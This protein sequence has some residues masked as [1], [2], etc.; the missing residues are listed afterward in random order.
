MGEGMQRTGELVG[1]EFRQIFRDPRMW[2][3]V[4]IAPIIQLLVFGYAVSTDVRNTALFVVDHDQ[5]QL[6]RAL[7]DSMTSSGYFRLVGTSERS[8]DVVGMLDHARAV[9]A[10]QIPPGFAADLQSGKGTVQLLFDGTNSNVA[11][12]A[13]GYA[14]RIIQTFGAEFRPM[15]L[16]GRPAIELRERAWFNPDLESRNYNVPA[17]TG[18][19]IF[20]ICLLLT[21][22]AI[23][24][25]R[26]MGTLEQLMV[27]PLQPVELIAGKSIPFAIIGL[28][29]LV[30]VTSVSLFW[31][32]VPFRGNFALLLLASV[33]YILSGLGIGLF[34]STISTTQQEAFMGMFLIFLPAVL[35]S[36][37]MF[38]VSSMP[39]LFQWLTVIN[40]VRHYL[41]IV[42]GI[43]LKGTG[44]MPLWPQYAALAAIGLAILLFAALRF[45]KRIA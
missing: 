1:K 26:E 6:S 42:R 8:S 39:P 29:D 43:F 27:S 11:M 10:L 20:L 19:I 38:P 30:I 7:V 41:E 45:E 34:I 35:L 12:V 44:F 15:S 31:F 40:P 2:R 28:I 36:G 3:V 24:R 17:V 23:V 14:E 13:R 32:D 9:A 33:L 16:A 22:L 37:F 25:E 4:L 18:M 5:T 21:A